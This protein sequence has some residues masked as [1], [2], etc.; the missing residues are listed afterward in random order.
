MSAIDTENFQPKQLE[1][2][3]VEAEMAVLGACL[4]SPRVFD[5]LQS[6]LDGP[7]FYEILY[8]DVW[9]AM[10]ELAADG[11]RADLVT[12]NP[13]LKGR[14]VGDVEALEHLS[15]L[16]TA[17]AGLNKLDDEAL[18]AYV[19]ELRHYS[20]QRK[21]MHAGRALAGRAATPEPRLENLAA[22]A[23]EEI[24]AATFRA[25][26]SRGTCAPIV[27]FIDAALARFDDEN[28]PA[29][30]PSGLKTLDAATGGFYRGEVSIIGGRPSMGKTIFG[31]Q[32]ALNAARKGIGTLMVS[33]EMDG[34]T[35]GERVVSNVS[36]I[37]YSFFRT[38]KQASLEN[39]RIAPEDRELL[40]DARDELAALPL[41]V[42]EK[43]GLT[44]AE[45]GALARRVRAKFEKQDLELGL[46]VVDYLGL[47]KP[48]NRYS[49]NRVNEVGEVSV[50]LKAMAKN[51][52]VHV[53]ALHQLNRKVEDRDDKRP[54]LSDLRDSGT[55][56]QDADL[57]LFAYREAYY[58]ERQSFPNDSEREEERIARL[59]EVQD[60]MEIIIGKSRSGSVG[61]MTLNV[62]V[63]C[64][65]VS[66][67]TNSK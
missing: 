12:L 67:F 38:D 29:G 60:Q 59:R 23:I 10:R 8:A 46:V 56:E 27:D 7:D 42:E 50:D 30:I 18:D 39:R 66:D 33:L 65:R 57:V 54:Q 34:M 24:D 15:L 61:S 35:L 9:R 45:I 44:I 4:G 25:T 62:D 51:L 47:V 19:N 31:T 21:L 43:A 22:V 20:A 49:G 52:G 13:T 37:P 5:R 36:T 32:I 26:K 3:N 11:R 28:A 58:L 55:I 64:S 17:Y 1:P 14:K 6:E 53:T 2:N 16:I 63:A 40:R 41:L 48:T